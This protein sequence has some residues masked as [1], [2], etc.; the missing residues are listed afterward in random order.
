MEKLNIAGQAVIAEKNYLDANC[1]KIFGS[2]SMAAFVVKNTVSEFKDMTIEEIIPCFL[3]EPEVMSHSVEDIPKTQNPEMINCMNS[4]S[5]SASEGEISY[6]V[7][8]AMKTPDSEDE[9]KLIVDIEAQ[10]D[11]F[12]NY[13]IT[14]RGT[15][16]IAREISSQKEHIFHKSEYDG[17]KKVYSI[18]I[19]IS[20]DKDA[21]GIMNVYELQERCVVGNYYFPKETYDKMCMVI[22]GLGD[23]T[24]P[25]EL[26]SMLS[27]VYDPKMAA[28]DKIKAVKECGVEVTT[29]LEGGIDN[30]YKY[31]DYVY[32]TGYA[33][34]EANGILKG[35]EEGRAEG[36]AEGKS[37]GILVGYLNCMRSLME[38]RSISFDDAANELKISAA[39]RPALRKELGL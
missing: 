37:K 16:Y 33:E 39:D 4:E 19:C 12:P 15:Y 13:H 3:G 18:W 20:P 23:K 9:I 26:I 27:K 34:G 24:S 31:S 5:K 6:D 21:R 30:M 28:E 14:S 17:I 29:E 35:K 32:D 8:F 25:N 22:V 1:K 38:G 10:N 11:F 36:M 7:I 2:K